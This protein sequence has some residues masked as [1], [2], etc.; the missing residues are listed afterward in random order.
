MGAH[1]FKD[2]QKHVGHK[3]VCVMYGKAHH[4]SD[5]VEA[6][7]TACTNAAIECKTC[8]EVLLDFDKKE[9]E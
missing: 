3:I 6:T 1:N 5:R 8:N 9:K 7:I 4:A 2:L